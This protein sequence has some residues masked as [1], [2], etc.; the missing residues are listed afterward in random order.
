MPEDKLNSMVDIMKQSSFISSI[1]NA[2]ISKKFVDI[3]IARYFKNFLNFF[4][5]K[6]KTAYEMLM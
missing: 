4:F 1:N 6:Q 2:E 5:F 3:Y